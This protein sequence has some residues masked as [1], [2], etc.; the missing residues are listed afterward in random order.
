MSAS[1]IERYSRQIIVPRVGGRAQERL[2]G[3][4]LVIAGD[5]HDV[6]PALLYLVGSGVG[7]IELALG[8]DARR[9]NELAAATPELNPDVTVTSL[10]DQPGSLAQLVLAIIG[11]PASLAS[12]GALVA[13][14]PRT[15]WVAARTDTPARIAVL[16]SPS[17]CPRC[18]DAGLLTPFGARTV[19]ASIFAMAATAEAFK[20]LAGYGKH[21]G[22][23]LIEF[24]G[25]ESRWRAIASD[26]ACECRKEGTW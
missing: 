6:E 15:G 26:P 2:L 3:A 9:A 14:F 13:R 17:P 10:S 18:A 20:L 19:N 12:V 7:R 23:T 8:R 5:A 25:Y 1:Q 11:S 24:D 21:P 22:A 16:P 4:R